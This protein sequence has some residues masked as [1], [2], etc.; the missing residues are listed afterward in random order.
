MVEGDKY[1]DDD[2]KNDSDD[3]S[4]SDSSD[5]SVEVKRRKK[6]F[7]SNDKVRFID[8]TTSIKYKDIGRLMTMCCR[9]VIKATMKNILKVNRLEMTNIIPREEIR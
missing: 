5:S 9:M 2:K 6:K 8:S 4:S 7:S 1:S 3:E